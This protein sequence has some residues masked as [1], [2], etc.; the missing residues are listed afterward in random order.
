MPYAVLPGYTLWYLRGGEGTPVVFLHG[1]GASSWIWKPVF[2]NTPAGAVYYA[3][4][5][6]GHGGSYPARSRTV[7]EYAEVLLAFIRWLASGPV[8]MVGHD[9]GAL[10]AYEAASRAPSLCAGLILLNALEGAALPPEMLRELDASPLGAVER[11]MEAL[12][13][14]LDEQLRKDLLLLLSQEGGRIFAGDLIA[15]SSYRPSERGWSGFCA[16]IKCDRD[17]LAR[18]PLLPLRYK[19]KYVLEGVGHF[20]MLESPKALSAA[21]ERLL[22]PFLRPRKRR[23]ARGH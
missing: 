9:M 4:D 14:G 22:S 17:P 23:A 18:E 20:P 6:P 1:A 16:L 10:V 2:L 7:E 21:V 19:E 8:V 15:C 12:G 5:L 11:Y 3:L 13:G